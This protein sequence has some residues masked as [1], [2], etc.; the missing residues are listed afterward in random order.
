[1]GSL[2]DGWRCIVIAALERLR[3]GDNRGFEDAL[4]LG[5]GDA[6]WPLRMALI[7]KGLI[8]ITTH[9]IY[10]SLTRRGEALLQRELRAVTN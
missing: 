9:S 6:W 10:P 5:L 1:M 4:W 2:P 7:R 3:R 8:E